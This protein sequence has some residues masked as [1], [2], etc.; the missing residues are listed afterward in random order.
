VPA[1]VDPDHAV[2]GQML[3]GQPAKPATV[4]RHPVQADDRFAGGVSPLRDAQ[5]H[6]STSFP[7]WVP[8][9]IAESASAASARGWTESTTGRH[10]PRPAALRKPS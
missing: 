2:G 9:S 7:K 1:V 10:E 4:A 5:L 8:A 3:L 6:D